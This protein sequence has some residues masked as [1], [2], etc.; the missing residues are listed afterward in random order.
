MVTNLEYFKNGFE[1]VLQRITFVVLY[2]IETGI[3]SS[4]FP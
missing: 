3:Y 4:L 1:C 2:M